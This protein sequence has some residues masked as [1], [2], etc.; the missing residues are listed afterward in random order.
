M[1]MF[2]TYYPTINTHWFSVRLLVDILNIFC[3][4]PDKIVFW[5]YFEIRHLTQYVS[6]STQK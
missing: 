2:D 3:H 6:K 4:N 5:L 1:E